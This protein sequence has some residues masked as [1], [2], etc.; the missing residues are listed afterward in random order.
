LHD[1]EANTTHKV[2][3]IGNVA[4]H[5]DYQGQGLMRRLMSYL[6]EHGQ[7][8]GVEACLL[9][10]DLHEFYGKLGY[11]LVG[12]EQRAV[13]SAQKILAVDTTMSIEVHSDVTER[14]LEM[15]LRLRPKVAKTLLR[16]AEEFRTLLRIPDMA[17]LT[18]EDHSGYALVGKGCDMGGVIHEWG[19]EDPSFLLSCMQFLLRQTGWQQVMLLAPAD[20]SGLSKWKELFSYGNVQQHAAVLAR[21]STNLDLSNLFV[22][23]LDSI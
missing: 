7:S 21:N 22:W 14:E 2:A 17:L 8:L 1:Y 5:T 11:H 9:W 19:A 13:F 15:Y 3:L 12:S 23:G 4:T 10:S 18:S 20:I 16:S 6:W